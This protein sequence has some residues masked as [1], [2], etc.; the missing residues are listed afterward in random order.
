[1][2]KYNSWWFSN[3][4]MM[5]FL[6]TLSNFYLTDEHKEPNNE[7]SSK[8]RV[9]YEHL[10]LDVPALIALEMRFQNPQP[11]QIEKVIV[12]IDLMNNSNGA[13]K[14]YEASEGDPHDQIDFLSIIKQ[15]YQNLFQNW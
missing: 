3:Q 14:M 1:M 7:N 12:L 4:F 11:P 2:N 9:I 5:N 8:N 13:K 15:V 10:F 6:Q